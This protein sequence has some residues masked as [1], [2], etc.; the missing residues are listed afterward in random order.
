MVSDGYTGKWQNV[1]T[2]TEAF[3]K[4]QDIWTSKEFMKQFNQMRKSDTYV[5]Q[6]NLVAA[7]DVIIT[8]VDQDGREIHSPQMISG[9]YVGET[10]DATTANYQLMIDDY[11]LDDQRLPGNATGILSDQEQTVTYVYQKN[12]DFTEVNVH[13]STIYVGDSWQAEDN[14]DEAFDK[15]G[16]PVAFQALIVD[17]QQV[18]L[19]QAGIYEVTYQYGGIS[20]V[21]Q[22]TVK[23]NQTVVNVHDATI[24]LGDKWQAEDNFDDVLDKAGNSVDFKEITVTGDVDTAQRGHYEI[25]YAY[26]NSMAKAVITVVAKDMGNH[27]TDMN[28]IDEVTEKQSEEI[29]SQEA[30]TEQADQQKKSLPATGEQEQTVLVVLGILLLMSVIVLFSSKK[31]Y[32]E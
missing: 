22:I 21:A 9:G 19:S 14:F 6:P 1:G 11:T 23:E 16:N 32:H 15:L 10:Y 25:T 18:N 13:D 3:P 5:W 7:K 4:G 31:M 20:S 17:D 24:Y 28:T 29:P 27:P 2:G 8:Y 26:G 30:T 12:Q